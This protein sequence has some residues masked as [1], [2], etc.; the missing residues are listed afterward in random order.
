MIRSRPAGHTA[1]VR[2][3]PNPPRMVT[4]GIALALGVVGVIYAWPIDGLV[5]LL[6]PL[7]TA[8]ASIGL[9]MD[10][11][12]GYLCLFA[13]PSLLVVGSLLPGI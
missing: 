7:S 6:D 2:L 11:E 4:V 9:A 12:M 10:R 13:C 1:V 3:Q 8:V 5:T